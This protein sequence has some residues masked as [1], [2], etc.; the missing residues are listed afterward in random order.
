MAIEL[1]SENTRVAL[2]SKKTQHIEVLDQIFTVN[3]ENLMMKF[4]ELRSY[5]APPEF[6]EKNDEALLTRIA[7]NSFNLASST[8]RRMSWWSTE[9]PVCDELTNS[10]AD[11]KRQVEETMSIEKI[12]CV[13]IT[14][15]S[16]F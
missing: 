8:I 11:L 2:W 7:R 4:E 15:P 3:R 10:I 1:G 9:D 12:T 14:V 13:V 6:E 5:L 16:F